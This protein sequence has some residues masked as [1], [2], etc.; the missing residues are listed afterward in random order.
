VGGQVDFTRG[1]A[2]SRGGKPIIA[3]PSTARG[4]SVSRIVPS[5]TAGAGVVTTRADVHYVVTEYGVAYLH[6]KSIRDRALSLINIAHPNFRKELIQEAKQRR[7]VYE[8]QIELAWENI[9]YPEELERRETLRD[10]MEIFFRPVK[11]TDDAKLRDMLYSLSAESVHRRFFTHTINFPH[12]DIQQLTNIDYQLALAIVGLVPGP[13][14]EEM[15]AIAQY[16]L[17][18][19]TNSAEVAFIVQDDWQA[20]GMGSSLMRYMTEIAIRRGIKAFHAKTLPTNRAML[21]VFENSGLPMSVEFDEDACTIIM[22]LQ[23]IR[24]DMSSHHG[25]H[26]S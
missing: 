18:P 2:R 6:G 15:V 16:F 24:L 1:A 19:K 7:Y 17:D 9:R 12:R 20:R 11:P 23:K 14:E 5:L 21:A 13:V 25:R 10:G 26:G 22:D 3:M 4:G 8:D